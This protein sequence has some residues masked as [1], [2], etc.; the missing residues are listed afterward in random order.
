MKHAEYTDFLQQR[1]LMRKFAR[2]SA[3]RSKVTQWT[4]LDHICSVHVDVANGQFIGRISTIEGGFSFFASNLDELLTA[5]HRTIDAHMGE[6][7]GVWRRLGRE[8]S[9]LSQP[10]YPM[11]ACAFKID[12]RSEQIS[13]N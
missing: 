6:S 13:A 4:Y 9:P 3:R 7:I 10:C 12:Q 5:F 8:P 2:R 11:Q 1:R